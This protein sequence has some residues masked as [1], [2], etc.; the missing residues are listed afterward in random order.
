MTISVCCSSAA[1]AAAALQDP[2]SRP[3]MLGPGRR[4]YSSSGTTTTTSTPKG[5]SSTAASPSVAVAMAAGLAGSAAASVYTRLHGAPIPSDKATW[6][7]AKPL[8]SPSQTDLLQSASG[9]SGDMD[10][11]TKVGPGGQDG[12]PLTDCHAAASS[13]HCTSINQRQT[14][15]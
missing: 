15:L 6:N 4:L 3:L 5:S 9:T 14:F 8:N 7:V 13:F 1:A 10:Q 2:D 12:S 11:V